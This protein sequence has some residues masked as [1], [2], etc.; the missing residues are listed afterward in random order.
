MRRG[1]D[2]LRIAFLALGGFALAVHSMASSVRADVSTVD[3]QMV[4]AKMHELYVAFRDLQPYL[5]RREAFLDARNEGAIT[6]LLSK[7]DTGFHRSGFA[8]TSYMQEP[9]FVST[10]RV[11]NEMLDDA[12]LRFAEGRK[13]YALWRLKTSSNYCVSC[14]TRF[15]VEVDFFDS[16]ASLPG[17]DKFEQGEFF[18]ASRQFDRAAAAFLAAASAPT[19][20]FQAIDALRKWLIIYVR[21]H[22]NPKAAIRELGKIL[23]TGEFA[24]YERQELLGWLESLMAWSKE[25]K[26]PPDSVEQA[27]LLLRKAEQASDLLAARSGTVELLRATSV[28]HRIMDLRPEGAA[29]REAH[30]LYLLGYAYSKLPLYFVNELPELF[31][32]R[33]IREAP[34]TQDAR[35]AY[36][37]L[38]DLLVLGYT[39]SGGT[40]MPPDV[41]AQLR[42]LHDLAF[43]VRMHTSAGQE[44]ISR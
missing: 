40:Q 11:L 4:R 44:V 33:A 34:D 39:G 21:V 35:D 15:E 10:L 13:G 1:W 12:R 25:S 28:L 36:N 7:L 14:H 3:Q 27:E 18:L 9:G 24:E 37:L 29:G 32:E 16:A 41:G 2:F 43:G 5:Y 38:R 23:R 17:L 6:A 42:E 26:A 22:P 31:L 19:E 30:I 20:R 8:N